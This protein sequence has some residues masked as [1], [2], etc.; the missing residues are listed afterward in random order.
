M[1]RSLKS[2]I[3]PSNAN[4]CPESWELFYDK[5]TF[6]SVC[7]ICHKNNKQCINAQIYYFQKATF[8]QRMQMLWIHPDGLFP[9]QR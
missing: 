3:S 5:K 2:F 1:F 9:I 7:Q 6:V 4:L 8:K